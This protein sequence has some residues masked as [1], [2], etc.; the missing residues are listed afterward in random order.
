MVVT[1]FVDTYLVVTYAIKYVE[2]NGF[3]ITYY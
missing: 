1:V 3:D 2:T